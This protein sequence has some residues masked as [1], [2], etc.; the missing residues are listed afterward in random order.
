MSFLKDPHDLDMR[1][2]K[3]LSEFVGRGKV[4]LWRAFFWDLSCNTRTHG[5]EAEKPEAP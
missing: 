4:G 2:L 5:T 1:G 3:V